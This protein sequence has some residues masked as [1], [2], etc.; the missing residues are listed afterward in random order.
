MCLTC[1]HELSETALEAENLGAEK[2]WTEVQARWQEMR[3]ENGE[4]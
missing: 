3:H 1:T 2:E 4:L